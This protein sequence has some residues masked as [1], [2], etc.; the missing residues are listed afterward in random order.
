MLMV[1]NMAKE[2]LEN[3]GWKV[4]KYDKRFRGVN[5]ASDVAATAGLS[6]SCRRSTQ[7]D[8]RGWERAL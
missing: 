7:D 6:L 5:R 8:R 4:E 3:H 1:V 2:M